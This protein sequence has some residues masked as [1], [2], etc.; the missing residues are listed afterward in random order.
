[1]KQTLR[2]HGWCSLAPFRADA[3]GEWLG[4][5]LELSRGR[6]VNYELRSSGR[7]VV[8]RIDRERS[9]LSGTEAEAA[10]RA[11]RRMLNFELDLS[12]FRRAAK[13]CDGLAW[14]ADSGMGRL[15]RCPTAWEDLAKLLLTT[16]CS[17]A[18]TQRMVSGLVERYGTPARD[19][20]RAF[21][22]PEAL[23]AVGARELRE[24][25]KVGYRAPLLAQ[26]AR[27]VAAGRVDPEKWEKDPRARDELRSEM[28]ELSGVGPYVAES[29]LKLV[30]RPAGLALDSWLRAEYAR[31]YHGG[32]PVQDRTIARR[33]ARM[34]DW[35]GL[36]LWCDM[37]RDRVEDADESD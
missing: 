8:A 3:S 25:A 30:G 23:A 34:G 28:L 5:V 19:G 16:N 17:W 26:L 36:A 4:G 6:A 15:L 35:A 29:M 18:L 21:P 31:V 33:Y 1:M 14:I 12:G 9:A 37:T 2:S 20:S 10:R 22:G 24:R 11:I 27:D 7:R 32:R 13:S